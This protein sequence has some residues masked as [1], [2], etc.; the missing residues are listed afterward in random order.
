MTKTEK[1]IEDAISHTW[2]ICADDFEANIGHQ[3]IRC[4]VLELLLDFLPQYA[5]DDARQ[6]W[7]SMTDTQKHAQILKY[8]KWDSFFTARCNRCQSE[9]ECQHLEFQL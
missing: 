9:P 6:L 1:C 3:A 2:N 5:D 7:K 8:F 4:E